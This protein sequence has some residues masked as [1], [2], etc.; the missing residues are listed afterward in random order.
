MIDKL[1][2]LDSQVHKYNLIHLRH[3]TFLLKVFGSDYGALLFISLFFF[4]SFLSISH[5]FLTLPFLYFNCL[6]CFFFK[7]S[8]LNFF[9]TVIEDVFGLI[10]LT[11]SR[12]GNFYVI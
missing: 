9:L 8:F 6:L 2:G 1:V 4:L 5:V 3:Y 11:R 10:K 12:Q 7:K